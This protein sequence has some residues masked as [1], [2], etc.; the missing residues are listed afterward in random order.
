MLKMMMMDLIFLILMKVSWKM[1]QII[2]IIK[3]WWMGMTLYH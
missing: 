2:S 1:D 3:R